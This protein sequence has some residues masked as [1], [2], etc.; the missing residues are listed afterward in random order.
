MNVQQVQDKLNE[1]EARIK[2]LEDEFS[3]GGPSSY[4]DLQKRVEGESAKREIPTT[5]Q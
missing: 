2:S 1:L 3:D 4:A 5:G